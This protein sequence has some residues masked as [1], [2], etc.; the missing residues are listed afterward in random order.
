MGKHDYEKSYERQ[1]ESIAIAVCAVYVFTELFI[2]YKSGWNIWGQIA[3]LG[4]A[5]CSWIFFFG[6]V[7]G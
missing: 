6:R 4:S 2:G 3:V 7:N 1:I 5:M